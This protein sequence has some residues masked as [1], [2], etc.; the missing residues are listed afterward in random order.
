MIAE[1]FSM[2]EVS[3]PA[4]MQINSMIY[5]THQEHNINLLAT[6]PGRSQIQQMP[7][8]IVNSD[9]RTVTDTAG[10]QYRKQMIYL[11]LSMLHYYNFSYAVNSV[12]TMLE[13]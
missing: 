7:L 2:M 8:D 6:S 13:K 5:V 11:L 4:H 9:T 3:A 12:T 10:A 1:T